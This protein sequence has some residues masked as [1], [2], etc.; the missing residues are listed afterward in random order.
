MAT[1]PYPREK[2]L[3]SK[4]ALD[5]YDELKQ[6]LADLRKRAEELKKNYGQALKEREMWFNRYDELLGLVERFLPLCEWME[7]PLERTSMSQ[8]ETEERWYAWNTTI[9]KL[10]A[11]IKKARGE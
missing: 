3:F 8:L 5:K 11:F 10:K 9:T 7:C 2:V 4:E 1:G 6:E